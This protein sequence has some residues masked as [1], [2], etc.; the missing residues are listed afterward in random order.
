MGVEALHSWYGSTSEP[1]AVP[2][3]WHSL[4]GTQPLAANFPTATS[5]PG[6]TTHM[7]LHLPVQA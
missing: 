2:Q 4:A 5:S 6:G 3:A 7:H 1:Y